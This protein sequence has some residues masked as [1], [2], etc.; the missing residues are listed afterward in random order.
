MSLHILRACKVR[1]RN[2]GLTDRYRWSADAYI[3][4]VRVGHEAEADLPAAGQLHIYLSK[5]LRV[6]EADLGP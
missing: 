1:A 3:T 5:Q 4:S 2:A 6:L